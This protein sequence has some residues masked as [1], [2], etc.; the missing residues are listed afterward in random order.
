GFSRRRRLVTSGLAG[1][2][3]RGEFVFTRDLEHCPAFSK[4]K[5]LVLNEYW[6][7]A[8]DLD[9]LACI[10][11]NSPVL[12]KL[13]LQLF[14]EG[15]NHE[16]EMEGSYCCMERPSAISEHLNIVEVKCN[17]VDKRILKILRFLCAFNIRFN[18]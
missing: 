13:T 10:L 7:E 15:P 14:S 2:I 4:L 8:P 1:A 9:P 11:K 5:T 18:F 12:E 3:R 16:V 17:V 6:C